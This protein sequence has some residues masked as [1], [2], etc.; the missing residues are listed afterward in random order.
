MIA[1]SGCSH[2]RAGDATATPD[3][4]DG[5]ISLFDGS[6]LDGWARRG[7][8]ADFR[9]EDGQIVGSTRPHEPN[10]FLCT[11]RE[12]SDFE[13]ELRFRT[14]QDLNSGVQFRSASLPDYQAGRVH[15]YQYEIDPSPRAWT[16]GVYDEGRRG[17][18]ASLESNPQAREAYRPHEWN[19]LRIVA[20]GDHIRT[21]INGVPAADFRDDLSPSGFIALQV[22]GVGD[23][24]DPLEARWTAIRIRP[25]TPPDSPGHE[26]GASAR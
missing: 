3:D 24:L 6:T 9:V 5:W 23:R 2:E 26:S 8:R 19:Q 17:W 13:L 11:V 25:I 10:G 20:R 12:Y 21:W 14:D 15:G 16:G 1:A 7:G 22:H 4:S 18:L